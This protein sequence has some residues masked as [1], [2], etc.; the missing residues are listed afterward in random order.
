MECALFAGLRLARGRGR[1]RFAGVRDLATI[2]DIQLWRPAK[3]LIGDEIKYW[4]S[5]GG[6]R[7][8][9]EELWLRDEA[10]MADSCDGISGGTRAVPPKGWKSA[11]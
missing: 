11:R 9:G 5:P 1:G 6:P 4:A 3:G 2:G 7:I 8:S 10:D